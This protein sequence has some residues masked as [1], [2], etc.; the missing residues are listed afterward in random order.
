MQNAS[1]IDF[2]SKALAAL[3][4]ISSSPLA[5]VGLIVLAV[6]AT[7]LFWKQ[8]SFRSLAKTLES[9]PERDRLERIRIDYGAR[10][11]AGVS[12]QNWLRSRRQEFLFWGYL[13][14]LFVALLAF[15]VLFGKTVDVPGGVHQQELKRS[16][17]GFR[18]KLA[19]YELAARNLRNA[20]EMA[21]ANA[22]EPD[23]E[24]D[25]ALTA[26]IE[27]YNAIYTELRTNQREYVEPVVR[28]LD[29]RGELANEVH[30]VVQY[31]MEDL[32]HAGI[33]QFNH[34]AYRR[35]QQFRAQ[36]GLTPEAKDGSALRLIR[37]EGATEIH[38]LAYKVDGLLDV[39]S[40]RMASLTAKIMGS[41]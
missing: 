38:D 25:Q 4:E 9:L 30:G 35:T 32:H 40:R 33:L 7:F 18:D 39:L 1:V 22:I 26:K 28:W 23:P 19:A 31:V 41:S 36:K 3:P 17:S 6:A 5:M 24:T 13:S 12:A 20:F 11:K 10:P 34:I 29:E 37:A 21:G 2:F 15:L 14:T 27:K 16:F 8:A